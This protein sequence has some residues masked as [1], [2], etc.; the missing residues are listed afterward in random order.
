MIKFSD[1]PH[2]KVSLTFYFEVKNAEIYGGEGSIGY[3]SQSMDVGNI[4]GISD[5][6]ISDFAEGMA[7][8]MGVS[9]DD[10]RFITEAEYE[11][12]TED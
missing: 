9:I 3:C 12:N 2:I 1:Y 5:K 11:E 8:F 10:V 4:D 6:H 7:N